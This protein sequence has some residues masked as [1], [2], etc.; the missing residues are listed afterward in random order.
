MCER[1]E[2]SFVET[3]RGRIRPVDK[4][5]RGFVQFLNGYGME[6]LYSCCGHGKFAGYITVKNDHGNLLGIL[7]RD[8]KLSYKYPFKPPRGYV[9]VIIPTDEI[10]YW[11]KGDESKS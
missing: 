2:I 9:N 6:T 4:C 10:G 11:R 5:L 1:G 3:H 7:G 8:G